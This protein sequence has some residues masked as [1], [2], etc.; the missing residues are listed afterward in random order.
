[1]KKFY[2]YFVKALNYKA[3][4]LLYLENLN[5]NYLLGINLRCPVNLTI[6]C[7]ENINYI[8][9]L[10]EAF[11]KLDYQAC[12]KKSVATIQPFFFTNNPG[13][14]YREKG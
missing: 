9:Y 11:R 4:L 12:T 1:L 6:V 2:V 14:L 3:K 8:N 7:Y 5:E 13:I 10:D